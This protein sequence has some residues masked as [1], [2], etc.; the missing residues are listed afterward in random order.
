[1]FKLFIPINIIS[2]SIHRL[3]WSIK[4]LNDCLIGFLNGVKSYCRL[5]V[6]NDVTLSFHRQ[7]KSMEE[8]KSHGTK[9]DEYGAWHKF[10]LLKNCQRLPDE[11]VHYR[12]KVINCLDH[13]IQTAHDE[14]LWSIALKP[15]NLMEDFFDE[16]THFLNFT[17]SSF[18]TARLFIIIIDGF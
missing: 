13:D 5:N 6:F 10:F 16:I 3:A 4:L 1:L 18:W 14:I 8:K 17:H 11:M 12:A 9:S 2:A 15:R 7:M